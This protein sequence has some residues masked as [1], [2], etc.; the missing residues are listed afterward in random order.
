M[1]NTTIDRLRV[2]Q[3]SLLHP[4]RMAYLFAPSYLFGENLVPGVGL[5]GSADD[6]GGVAD[7]L[8]VGFDI[9]REAVGHSL[10]Q[11]MVDRLLFSSQLNLFH[12]RSQSI[13]N[14]TKESRLL[15]R[16]PAGDTSG[17]QSFSQ[18]SPGRIQEPLWILFKRWTRRR[19]FSFLPQVIVFDT[20]RGILWLPADVLL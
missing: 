7:P 6:P 10:E 5:D 11:L 8:H 4:G 19:D 12:L 17:M 13:K 18:N 9:Q 16:D 2:P 15:A 20:I 3:G 1:Y 14:E